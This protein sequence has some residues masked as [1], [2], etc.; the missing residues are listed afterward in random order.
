MEAIEWAA[1][2]ADEGFFHMPNSHTITIRPTVVSGTRTG[3]KFDPSQL[4]ADLTDPN[5]AVVPD[6]EVIWKNIDTQAHWPAI[7]GV[8]NEFMPNQIAPNSSSTAWVVD[9]QSVGTITYF[10]QNDGSKARPN[11]T[12]VVTTLS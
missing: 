11:G 10:D 6:D 3:Y 5:R 8:P 4:P 7:A 9:A 1:T 2:L 12:I